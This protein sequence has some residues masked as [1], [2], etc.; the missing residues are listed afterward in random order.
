MN[1]IIPTSALSFKCIKCNCPLPIFGREKFLGYLKEDVIS[2]HQCKAKANLFDILVSCIDENFFFND[3]FVFAGAEKSIFQFKLEPAQPTTVIF[4]HYGIPKGARILHLN[5]TPQGQGLFPLEF[6]GNSPY[7]G[8]PRESVTLYPAKF[9]GNDEK[10]TEINV[11][12]TWVSN[13]SL[14]D[15]SLKSLVDALEEYSHEEYTACIVPANTSIEFDVMRCTEI[16]LE[17]VSS[18]N[19][20]K[21]FFNSGISYVPT[22]KVLIPLISRLKGFPDMPQEILTSLVTLATFRN[23][24]AHTGKTRSTLTKNQIAK[25]LTGVILGKHYI[26]E[27]GNA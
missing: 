15:I 5:Y 21:E 3:V 2:C 12:A 27:L 1:Q 16:I 18:K 20:V 8:M 6:H 7:R 13:D 4:E 11:M 22:L 26:N 23:Q 14:E 25:C 19:Y 24:I 9:L 17:D 10:A